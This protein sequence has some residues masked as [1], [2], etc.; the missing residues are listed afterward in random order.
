MSVFFVLIILFIAVFFNVSTVQLP[1]VLR[2]EASSSPTAGTQH[3]EY[4]AD[5]GSVTVYDIDNNFNVATTISLPST[6]DGIRGEDACPAKNMLY[7]AHGTDGGSGGKLLGYNLVTKQIV[8]D[9][10][11][12]HGIDQFGVAPDCSK[13][14]MP[15]G[16][17]ANDSNWYVEDGMTGK[18]TGVTIN[19]GQ[20]PHNT[21][22]SP[23]GSHV[24]MG[25]RQSDSVAV[26]TTANN[27]IT[28]KVGPL[29]S[30]ST[31]IRPFTINA[32]QTVIYA[33]KTGFLGFD[34][35]DLNTG[36]QLFAVPVSGFT[37][38]PS[39][40]PATTPSHGISLSPDSNTLYLL[41]Q[42]NNYIHIFDVSHVPSSAPVKT[43]D[44]KL[45][46][47]LSGNESP[48]AYDCLRDGWLQLSSD[49]KYLFV[50]D[51]G[52][53]IDTAARNV[54]AH[55]SAL[56]N[57]RHGLTEVDWTNG[58][59]SFTTTPFSVGRSG[60]I[61]NPASGTG[62]PTPTIFQGVPSQVCLGHCPTMPPSGSPVPGG[63]VSPSQAVAPSASSPSAP[64][65]S[66]S[67]SG[68]QMSPVPNQPGNQRKSK[69]KK[70]SNGAIRKLIR[71]ILQLLLQI[72]QL[73]L[74]LLKRG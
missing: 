10:T 24:Y 2:Q 70:V 25:P 20:G 57:S 33:V 23:D 68:A 4:I 26:A 18:D 9:V 27:T 59:P 34:V 72:I 73:I 48:C 6:S 52:D 32:A 38:N 28:L 19:G 14:Y 49:G 1:Q 62:T 47:P 7:I 15:G 3:F 40:D 29:S 22:V 46:T 63:S 51:S 67:P 56:Q 65:L 50:G 53:V 31:G 66:V 12:S 45:Q 11:Y 74:R 13:V 21:I 37:Y 69:H 41:D 36:K 44:I 64:M 55:L 58:V 42:F 17:V 54:V 16:E 39:S 30:G 71:Q 61:P 5:A 8:F 35:G 43:A 60:T